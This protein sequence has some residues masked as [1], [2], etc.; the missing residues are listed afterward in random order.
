MTSPLLRHSKSEFVKRGPLSLFE[1]PTF[2]SSEQDLNLVPS[3]CRPQ[4]SRVATRPR[5]T[6]QL[7]MSPADSVDATDRAM[8][9]GLPLHRPG[10]HRSST[11]SSCTSPGPYVASELDR[12][13]QCRL[14]SHP[15]A[16]RIPTDAHRKPTQPDCICTIA[17]S[18]PLDSASVA[19]LPEKS[20]AP[21][22][23][24]RS[25]GPR[26]SSSRDNETSGTIY[27]STWR[28]ERS[29]RRSDTRRSPFT[30]AAATSRPPQGPKSEGASY[31]SQVR[32]VGWRWVR[33]HWSSAGPTRREFGVRHRA[34][35]AG[36][37]AGPL[38]PARR[39]AENPARSKSAPPQ[40]ARGHSSGR[41]GGA[42]WSTWPG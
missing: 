28:A 24:A 21:H 19:A 26:K 18:H 22:S 41:F 4:R 31:E 3:P 6:R 1:A 36:S 7:V 38:Q 23:T 12:V 14:V 20:Q 27:A 25:C 13:R 40:P 29:R 5:C 16:A 42:S 39:G 2:V 30:C 9:R 32:G 8:Y 10:S 15:S 11:G 34:Q 33:A 17:A 37:A 35:R